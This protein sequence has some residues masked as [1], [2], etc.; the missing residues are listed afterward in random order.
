MNLVE[1]ILISPQV[2]IY[3]IAQQILYF[4]IFNM[5]SGRISRVL[6]IVFSIICMDLAFIVAFICKL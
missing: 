1:I 6:A 2:R 5:L 4:H 3:S